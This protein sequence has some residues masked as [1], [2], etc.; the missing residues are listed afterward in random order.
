M[1]TLSGGPNIVMDGLVMYLDAGNRNSYPGTGTTWT[2]I[3]RSGNNGTL[4]NGPTFNNAS[5]G[6]FVF[7]GVN[8]TTA[9]GNILN[10]GLNSW[11]V[12]CWVKL[13]STGLQGIIG[14]TSARS[15]VGRYAFF[16]EASTL[17]ALIQFSANSIISTPVAPYINGKFHN[18][19][20]SANRTGMMYF[21]INGISVGT[22][23][24]ISSLS[25]INLNASTDN[26][27][28]GSYA[29]STGLSPFYYL[30]GSIAQASIYS[31]ALTQ[32]EVL[33]NYNAT[34]ARFGL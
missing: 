12:S 29:D 28:V 33:Q 18:L 16:I 23:V 27:Y 21:Y 26:L 5:G 19:V 24:D 11:T 10:I 14:K 9:F 3:S 8:D 1:S 34:R 15:Y 4:T 7:D 32:T 31:K 6:S 25:G 17:Y 2:D 22:P 20:M 30:N 13:N